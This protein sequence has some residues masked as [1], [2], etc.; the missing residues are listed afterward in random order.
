M[1]VYRVQ[2]FYD[3]DG[4]VNFSADTVASLV[5]LGIIEC[6]DVGRPTDE[7]VVYYYRRMR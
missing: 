2:N 5:S 6:Y 4:Y 7:I 1:Y 3:E